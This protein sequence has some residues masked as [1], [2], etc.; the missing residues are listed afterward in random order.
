LS[1]H[2]GDSV[3]EGMQVNGIHKWGFTEKC[4]KNK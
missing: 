3:R 1:V 4:L 2:H